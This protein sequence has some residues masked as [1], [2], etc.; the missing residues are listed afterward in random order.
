M[1]DGAILLSIIDVNVWLIGNILCCASIYVLLTVVYA[2]QRAFDFSFVRDELQLVTVRGITFCYCVLF[3][4]AALYLFC[5][6]WLWLARKHQKIFS[7]NFP[8]LEF[9]FLCEKWWKI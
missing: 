5:V 3:L 4:S 7:F 8:G 6:M 1:Y 9:R 2:Y